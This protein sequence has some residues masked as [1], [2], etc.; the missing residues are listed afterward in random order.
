[1][2]EL[3]PVPLVLG[4]APMLVVSKMVNSSTVLLPRAI[5]TLLA[6]VVVNVRTGHIVDGH[7]RVEEAIAR[8]ET[9][10]VTHVD[11]S[12]EEEDLVLATLDPIGAMANTDE[13]KLN[14]L[15]RGI[16]VDDEEL[17]VVPVADSSQSQWIKP[18]DFSARLADRLHKSP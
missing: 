9:V 13:A 15:L 5:M 12:Q 14:E 18:P 11:L 6:T 16:T 2:F 4:G 8:G 10:P 17:A 3:T 7:A 1:M